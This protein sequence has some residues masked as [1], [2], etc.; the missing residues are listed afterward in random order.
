MSG[1][2][3]AV[4]RAIDS[5]RVVRFPG[6]GG[7]D[8]GE[9]LNLALADKERS[10]LGNA[11]RLIARHG[12]D[13]LFVRERGWHCWTG[14]HWRESG[15]EDE[16]KRRAHETARS[17]AE[18]V[19]ALQKRGPKGQ[20]E[21]DFNE[22]LKDL[23]KWSVSS[24][25]EDKTRKMIA[26]A[27]PYLSAAPDELDADPLEL[28]LMNGTLR[29]AGACDVL[30]GHDRD[31]L[32]AK[33]MP[34]EYLPD[35]GPEPP[36]FTEFLARVQPDPEIRLFLQVWCGYCL[37]GLTTEQKLVFNFG[38]GSNGKSVFI[39][40]IAKMMGPYAV[41][42]PFSS[43]LR[44]DRKRGA[45]ATPDL[46][47]L[48]G[49]RMV[50]ASEPEKGSRFAEA[51]IKAITGGE[52]VT[53]RKLRHD[54]FDFMPQFKLILSGNH[55]PAIRGQDHG[56]WRRF[57]LVPWEVTIPDDQ[58]DRGLPAKLW[59]ERSGVLNWLLDGARIWLERGLVVPEV[60]RAKTDEYKAES[61]PLGRFIA[62]CVEAAPNENVRAQDMYEAYCRW[63]KPNSERPWSMTTFGKAMPERGYEKTDGRIRVYRNVRLVNVPEDSGEPPPPNGPEDYE[64]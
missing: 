3:G 22:R 59:E 29:I 20:P 9:R 12:K 14:T 41:S 13:L 46:A 27:L 25:N 30:R 40:L 4:R 45:D 63:C 42:L 33:V 24:G 39:D 64:D 62:D 48:P 43:L 23:L 1:G 21:G 7:D 44:D 34:V 19:D 17:I 26:Q 8:G 37:T 36:L 18:E 11:E 61:D 6:G 32:L 49:A 51:T 16:V 60:I 5:A 54:F 53:V 57:L 2:A 55:K 38:G 50:R 58:Q 31:D 10:D 28:N 56:I 47:R 35:L 52:E 15:A